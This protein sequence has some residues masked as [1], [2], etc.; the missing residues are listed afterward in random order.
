MTKLLRF[1]PS[2]LLLLCAFSISAQELPAHSDHN[3]TSCTHTNDQVFSKSELTN[4]FEKNVFSYNFI[5]SKQIR[6]A[7]DN[8]DH[9]ISLID[10]ISSDESAD[11]NCSAGFCMNSAHY[12]KKGLTLNRQLFDYFLS[13]S[14]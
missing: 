4:S 11:F 10:V 6:S 5:S 8:Q 1:T 13:I 12:H 2:I 7:F 9:S 14:C 3:H